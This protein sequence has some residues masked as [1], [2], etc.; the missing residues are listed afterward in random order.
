MKMERKDD[1]FGLDDDL[2]DTYI[3]NQRL[4]DL[5]SHPTPSE[6]E[7]VFGEEETVVIIDDLDV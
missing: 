5:Q 6:R 7:Y 1:M 2:W 3:T 4:D